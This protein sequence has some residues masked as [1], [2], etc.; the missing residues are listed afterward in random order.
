[1]Y[2]NMVISIISFEQGQKE[3]C[4]GF[5]KALSLDLRH[6]LNAYY[7][8]LVD[9]KIPRSVWMSYVQGFQ[10]WGAGEVVGGVYVEYDGLSG[11]QQPLVP[12][13][14]AFLGLD[15][16]L[17]E[18]NRLRYIP[19]SQRKL[20]ASLREHSFRHK[21]KWAGDVAIEGEM[22]KIVKQMRVGLNRPPSA[23]HRC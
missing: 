6:P 1:M 22:E 9:S 8:T 15:P 16:Y 21:A 23:R 20:S 19:L 3:T 2:Y 17:S 5:L 14:D 18:V 10:D 11:N 12:M 13:V 7:T 4:L